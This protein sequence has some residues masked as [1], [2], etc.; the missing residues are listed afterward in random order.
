MAWGIAFPRP[1]LT[2]NVNFLYAVAA[3][4][5]LAAAIAFGL[6]AAAASKGKPAA[7]G[8]GGAKKAA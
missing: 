3:H 1:G 8:K 2:H 6:A 7:T 4:D 5:V